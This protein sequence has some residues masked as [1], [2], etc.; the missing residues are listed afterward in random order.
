GTSTDQNPTYTYATAGLYDVSLTVTSD[1]GCT[2]TVTQQVEVFSNPTA[3][4]TTND[5]CFGT[6]ANFNS[7]ASNGNGGTIDQWSWDFD[8][9][10]T[11][12][13]SDNVT[14]NPSYNYSTPGTY[15]V[16]LIVTTSNGCSD[17][18]IES[19]TIFPSPLA[20]FTFND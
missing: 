19:I 7:S 4:F 8:Y 16:Q 9:D 17:T 5:V 3:A 14:Q 15:D 10:G 11:T 20:D 12:H 13:T 1:S 6:M 18:I 2:H